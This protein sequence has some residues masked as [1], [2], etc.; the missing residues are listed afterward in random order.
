MRMIKSD[1]SKLAESAGEAARML[2]LLANEKRLLVLCALAVKGEASVSELAAEADLGMSALSQ[3]LAKLREDGLVATRKEA[4]TVYYR[5]DD[6]DAAKIL[7]T[8]KDIY[9]A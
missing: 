9:C 6:P 4:Q 1:I 8:L 5:I 7:K 2:R 3:H